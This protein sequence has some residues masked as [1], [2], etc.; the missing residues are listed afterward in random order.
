MFVLRADIVLMV[1]IIL[2][3]AAEQIAEARQTIAGGFREICPA[4]KWLGFRCE[5]HRQGPTARTLGEH[6]VRGLVNLVNIR[7]LLA[8]NLDI[9][10]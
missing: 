10:E 4:K 1:T 5:E 3:H 6:C 9:D 2:R 7:P 8:V